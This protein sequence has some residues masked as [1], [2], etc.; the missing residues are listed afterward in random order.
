MCLPPPLPGF[1][2]LL[3]LGRSAQFLLQGLDLLTLQ[4]L[5][6]LGLDLVERRRLGGTH[7]VELDDVVAE[8]GLDRDDGVF[9]LLQLSHRLGEFLHEGVG[10]VPAQITAVG[11]RSGILGQLGQ[12]LEALALLQALDDLLGL[13]RLLAVQILAVGNSELLIKLQKYKSDRDRKS[14]V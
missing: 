3:D 14:V 5:F 10:R 4:L 13:V 1:L 9:T 11:T 6:Q 12:R 2:A 7:V 8:L